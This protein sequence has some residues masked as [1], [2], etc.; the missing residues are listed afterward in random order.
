[1]GNQPIICRRQ[2]GK[3]DRLR[4]SATARYPV[5]QQATAAWEAKVAHAT[6]EGQ[7]LVHTS[8]PSDCPLWY[9][10]LGARRKSDEMAEPVTAAMIVVISVALACFRQHR[11]VRR[12]QPNTFVI[13]LIS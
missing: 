8:L 9:K 2:T 10:N 13:H 7:V 4:K 12:S 6:F 1:L 11:W 3:E 5:D